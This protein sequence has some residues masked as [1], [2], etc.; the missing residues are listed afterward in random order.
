MLILATGK[1]WTTS[2]YSE[3]TKPEVF[4]DETKT[5]KK[6]KNKNNQAIGFKNYRH[7]YNVEILNSLNPEIQFKNT[8]SVIKN[9]LKNLLSELRG[10][11]FVITFKLKKE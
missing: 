4:F 8:K 5:M 6:S 10:C 9:K 1:N 2:W 7:I 11:K 3:T